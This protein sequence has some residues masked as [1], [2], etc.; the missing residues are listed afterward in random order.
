L[1]S[2]KHTSGSVQPGRLNSVSNTDTD[3]DPDGAQVGKIASMNLDLDFDLDLNSD[4][5]ED[6]DPP[7]LAE[8]SLTEHLPP[9]TRKR[10]VQG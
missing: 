9:L 3:C 8:I 4:L 7:K 1:R 5:D 6:L 10:R 2:G